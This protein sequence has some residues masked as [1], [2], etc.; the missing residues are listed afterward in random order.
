[1]NFEGLKCVYVP[2]VQ[3]RNG[4]RYSKAYRYCK[5]KKGVWKCFF[6]FLLPVIVKEENSSIYN[7]FVEAHNYIDFDKVPNSNFWLH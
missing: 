4:T 6:G 1:M 2:L 3:D 7:A 5:D